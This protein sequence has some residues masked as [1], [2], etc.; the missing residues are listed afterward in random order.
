MAGPQDLQ[1]AM[2]LLLDTAEESLNTIPIFAPGL[3]GAP[4]RSYINAGQPAYDCCDQLT[5]N[6]WIIREAPTAAG[7][8]M[9]I[10]HRFDYRIN[11]VG[12]QVSITRCLDTDSLTQPPPEADLQALARQTNADG[13]ALWNHFWNEARA[14]LLVTICDEVFFDALTPVQPSGG[15]AGWVLN[16]RLQLAG[17]NEGS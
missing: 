8:D 12:A 11:H 5:V 9:G 10:K 6:A 16:L 3:G 17:Y 15:C 4:E 7:L 2:Q 14:G 1:T 13:W